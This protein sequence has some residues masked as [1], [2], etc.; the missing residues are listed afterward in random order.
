MDRGRGRK[1][2]KKGVKVETSERLALYSTV[3]TQNIVAPKQCTEQ[4]GSVSR[5]LRA[6]T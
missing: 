4:K 6:T 2:K 3:Q 1:K 5:S